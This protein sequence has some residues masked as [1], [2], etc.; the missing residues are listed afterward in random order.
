VTA[1]ESV[2]LI[3]AFVGF[4]SIEN[5]CEYRSTS[6]AAALP[7]LVVSASDNKAAMPR[8]FCLRASLI[9][10]PEFVDCFLIREIAIVI[11]LGT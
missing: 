5:S 3:G 11:A 9:R 10:S 6:C 8:N 4:A 2:M 1:I 7:A